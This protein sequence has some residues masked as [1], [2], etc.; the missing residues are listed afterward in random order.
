VLRAIFRAL[1]RCVAWYYRGLS[2]AA[3]MLLPLV[4]IPQSC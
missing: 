1:Q 3:S 2:A 4:E